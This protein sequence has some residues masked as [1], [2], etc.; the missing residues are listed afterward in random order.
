MKFG[1][2]DIETYVLGAMI[3]VGMAILRSFTIDTGLKPK[4]N[5]TKAMGLYKRLNRALKN[6]ESEEKTLAFLRNLDPHLFEEL[7][8]FAFKKQGYVIF[9]NETYSNTRGHV[10]Q[11]S[12]Y[13]NERKLIQTKIYTGVWNPA[14]LQDFK[15]VVG[16]HEQCNAGIFVHTEKSTNLPANDIPNIDVMDGQ[17]LIELIK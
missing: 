10:G 4:K 1:L 3:I 5:W 7:V 14:D 11:I 15:V 12:T 8:M 6:G 9:R 16:Q 17:Q 13:K 2:H